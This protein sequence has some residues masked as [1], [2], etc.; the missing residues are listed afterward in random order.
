MIYPLPQ[1]EY[2]LAVKK[3]EVKFQ[4]VQGELEV[5][6]DEVERAAAISGLPKEVDKDFWNDWLAEVYAKEVLSGHLTKN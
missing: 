5:L 1:S 3:G 6:M 4:Y 2:I